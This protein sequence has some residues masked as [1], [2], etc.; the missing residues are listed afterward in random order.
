MENDKQHVLIATLNDVR[1]FTTLLRCVAFQQRVKVII[2]EAGLSITVEEARTLKSTAYI[3][4]NVFT[5]YTFNPPPSSDLDQTPLKSQDSSSPPPLP[6]AALEINLTHLIECL[7]IFGTVGSSTGGSDETK[8]GKSRD[9]GDSEDDFP[10][11]KKDLMSGE[12]K[13]VRITAGRISWAGPGEPLELVL[14]DESS[15]SAPT[16]V[17]SLST[18]ETDLADNIDL[19]PPDESSLHIICRASWL[20]DALSSL[21]ASTDKVT[22]MS[23]VPETDY[24]GKSGKSKDPGV[25]FRIEADSTWGGVQMDFKNSQ[26]L[27]LLFQRTES[28]RQTYRKSLLLR[29]LRAITVSA[30]VSIQLDTSGVFFMQCMVPSTIPLET[31]GVMNEE[32]RLRRREIKERRKMGEINDGIVEFSMMC[33][34]DMDED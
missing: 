20:R 33:L 34:E 8:K 6:D 12:A 30:R 3:P 27:C 32:E 10:G 16:T 1:H 23:I 5:T 29:A 18:S 14:K 22:F 25:D 7:S 24:A 26:P 4:N 9:D 15:E 2:S 11:R 28:I 19:S 21:D 31:T 13:G 17:C